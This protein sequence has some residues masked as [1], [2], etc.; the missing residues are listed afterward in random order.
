MT[1]M[2]GTIRDLH[3]CG[4]P[5]LSAQRPPPPPPRATSANLHLVALVPTVK[6]DTTDVSAYQVNRDL[7]KQKRNARLFTK[8][9]AQADDKAGAGADQRKSRGNGC[10]LLK[11]LEKELGAKKAS[12]APLLQGIKAELEAYEHEFARFAAREHEMLSALVDKHDRK[13]DVK[14]VEAKAPL[15]KGVLRTGLNSS[16]SSRG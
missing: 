9:S 7:I 4:S 13:A 15:R 2:Q 1:P 16:L 8:D 11:Q 3:S 12:C 5:L 10:D 14:Q 6:L